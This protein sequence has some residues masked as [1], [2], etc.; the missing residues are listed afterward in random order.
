MTKKIKLITASTLI[1]IALGVIYFVFID[2]EKFEVIAHTEEKHLEIGDEVIGRSA[3]IYDLNAEK[4]IAGKNIS[5]PVPIASITKLAAAAVAYE[6]L[7]SEDV[8]QITNED[9]KVTANTPLQIGE[10][11]ETLDLLEFSLI[12][13]S[14]I[15]IHAVGRT[16]EQKTGRPLVDLMNEFAK[17]QGLVQTH[18]INATGLDAHIGLSGSESSAIDIVHIMGFVLEKAPALAYATTRKRKDFFSF[19]GSKYTAVNTNY[20]IESYPNALLSKTGFTTIAGGTLAVVVEIKKRP[21]VIITLQSTK[22]GRF[23]DV[24]ELANIAYSLI[25]SA[26]E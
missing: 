7:N 15:G 17:E 11:W 26:K 24:R 4:V 25:E 19:G 12:T 3:I 6:L 1:L 20:D 22:E 13:S 18:F 5:T 14:N 9:L 21:V 8:T 2:V 23:F 10:Q 16:V